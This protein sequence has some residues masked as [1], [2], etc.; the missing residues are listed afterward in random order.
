MAEPGRG[1][2]GFGEAIEEAA[3]ALVSDQPVLSPILA[4]LT[5]V[6][7]ALRSASPTGAATCP[8][9]GRL[10]SAAW[11]CPWSSCADSREAVPGLSSPEPV[12]RRPRRAL[13]NAG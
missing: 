3:G 9:D 7:V 10:R 11:S 12:F 4:G 8:R 5:L 2:G 1:A 13:N 6:A